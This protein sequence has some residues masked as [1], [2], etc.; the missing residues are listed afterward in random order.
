[1][2][3]GAVSH[4]SNN[5]WSEGLNSRQHS[6]GSLK[7]GLTTEAAQGKGTPEEIT[8]VV[9]EAETEEEEDSDNTC[10]EAMN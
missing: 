8:V 2:I 6:P 9:M 4:H 7:E 1:M 10:K 3:T 5:R